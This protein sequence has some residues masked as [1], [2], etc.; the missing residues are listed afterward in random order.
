[1]LQCVKEISVLDEKCTK[2]CEGLYVTSYF[3][4][5]MDDNSFAEFWS[6][7]RND[8][9]NYKGRNPVL[10]PKELKG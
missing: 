6:K 5:R 4:S 10:F 7:V 2:R 9:M 8:Y 3:K 1:M